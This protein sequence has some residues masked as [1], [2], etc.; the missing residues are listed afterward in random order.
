LILLNSPDV[1]GSSGCRSYFDYG[2][3]APNLSIG[4]PEVVFAAPQQPR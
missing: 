4:V 3:N 2:G 1:R